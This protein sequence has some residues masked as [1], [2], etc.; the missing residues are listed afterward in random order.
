M[1]HSSPRRDDDA[2]ATPTYSSPDGESL[3]IDFPGTPSGQ[4][5]RGAALIVPIG[6][7]LKARTLRHG[8]DPRCSVLDYAEPGFC[9]AVTSGHGHGDRES[10]ESRAAAQTVA[11]CIRRGAREQEIGYADYVG[12]DIILIEEIFPEADGRVI[13]ACSPRQIGK[14]A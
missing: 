13:D 9:W 3:A 8:P 6:S 4:G 1:K 5:Q 14:P 12:I 2:G 11:Q 10:G 7:P